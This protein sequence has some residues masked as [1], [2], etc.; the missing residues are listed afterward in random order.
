MS[1]NP[2]LPVVVTEAALA[3][4]PADRAKRYRGL[5]GVAHASS[6][7]G[8]LMVFWP[9]LGVS[10]MWAE[11]DLCNPD[12]NELDR[13]DGRPHTPAHTAAVTD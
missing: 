2:A 3:S 7:H 11:A 12:Q 13:S 10:S 4:G 1:L 5:R 9:K 8:Y 6:R